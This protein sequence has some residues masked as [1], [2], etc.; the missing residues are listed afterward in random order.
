MPELSLPCTAEAAFAEGRPQTVPAEGWWCGTPRSTFEAFSLQAS[1]VFFARISPTYTLHL[2]LGVS[3]GF[4]WPD[5]TAALYLLVYTHGYKKGV[6]PHHCKSA[7]RGLRVQG[8]I[9]N[10]LLSTAGWVQGWLG[11]IFICSGAALGG[12]SGHKTQVLCL[13][14]EIAA[15]A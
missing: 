8:L 12:V 7:F 1:G 2:L 3:Q 10:R 14:R 4:G 6:K 9:F 13:E 11:C 5:R 15:T